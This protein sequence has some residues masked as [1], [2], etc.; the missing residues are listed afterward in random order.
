[1]RYHIS[2]F[3]TGTRMIKLYPSEALH[4][5]IKTLATFHNKEIGAYILDV[6]RDKLPKEIS[7]DPESES[8]QKPRAPKTS[9]VKAK[10]A[11]G[12]APAP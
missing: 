7:F 9:K 12:G 2:Q 6:L 8:Q 10:K 3:F 5:W 1:M 4:R 11:K